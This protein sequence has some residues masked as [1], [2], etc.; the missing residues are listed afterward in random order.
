MDAYRKL[1]G[2]QH[3]EIPDAVDHQG[4]AR[5]PR[6][7]PQTRLKLVDESYWELTGE[8]P[9]ERVLA[10][11]EEAGAARP[12]FW[13]TQSAKGRVFVSIPGHCSWTFDDPLFRVVL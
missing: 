12:L 5:T 13:T 6:L 2:G 4:D 9:A 10:T 8:L 11:Q 7:L 3:F 1:G